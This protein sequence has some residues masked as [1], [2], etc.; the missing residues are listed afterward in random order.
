MTPKTCSYLLTHFISV[1]LCTQRPTGVNL[2]GENFLLKSV[3]GLNL[4]GKYGT[5]F[6]NGEEDKTPEGAAT[7]KPTLERRHLRPA[8]WKQEP[9]EPVECT[10][11]GKELLDEVLKERDMPQL[12]EEVETHELQGL[13]LA[14]DMI[15]HIERDE[16][17]VAHAFKSNGAAYTHWIAGSMRTASP[18]GPDILRVSRNKTRAESPTGSIQR[19][20]SPARSAELWQ[21]GGGMAAPLQPLDASQQSASGT[22]K[23]I[24]ASQ[25]SA[26]SS[27]KG[28]ALT[29]QMA[30]DVTDQQRSFRKERVALL[31][32]VS[33]SLRRD[34]S[35]GGIYV[36][37]AGHFPASPF[38]SPPPSSLLLCPPLVSPPH[39]LT[40]HDEETRSRVN[41]P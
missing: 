12:K 40:A 19:S 38:S 32:K 34:Q 28:S 22:S 18:T 21:P 4:T 3:G 39:P 31:Q 5:R 20:T 16:L 27:F 9:G 23:S 13:H 24:F 8:T 33:K 14:M 17:D 35:T 29:A 25:K 30:D 10:K 26:G 6:D 7:R 1:C 37:I 41:Q 2:E 15:E 36:N 11:S